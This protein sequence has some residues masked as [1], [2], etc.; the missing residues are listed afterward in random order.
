MGNFARCFIKSKKIANIVYNNVI[1][2]YGNNKKFK[3]FEL[4]EVCSF[5]LKRCGLFMFKC[6]LTT[7]VYDFLDNE[8]D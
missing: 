7:H 6:P 8:F 2:F 4:E 5:T 1:M 3:Y